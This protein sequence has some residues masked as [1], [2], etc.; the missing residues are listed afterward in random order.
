MSYQIAIRLPEAD[1][2]ALDEAIA[3]GRFPNRAAALREGL[4]RLLRAEREREI[5]EAYR[6][7]YGAQPQ[8]DWLGQT[9]LAAFAALVGAEERDEEPL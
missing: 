5:E 6:R 8:E 7:G 1:V 9:G 3:H 2:S 4:R